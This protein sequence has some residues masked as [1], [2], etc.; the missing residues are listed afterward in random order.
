MSSILKVKIVFLLPAG[1]AGSR[2]AYA[3]ECPLV[4]L[5]DSISNAVS[6]L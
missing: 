5:R 2:V 6:L 3:C 1:Y 4:G